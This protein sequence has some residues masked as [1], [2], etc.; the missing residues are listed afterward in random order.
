MHKKRIVSLFLSLLMIFGLMMPIQAEQP[1][2]DIIEC[3]DE[4]CYSFA[5]V[6]EVFKSDEM[7]FEE[8]VQMMI[9]ASVMQ[10]FSDEGIFEYFIRSYATTI[11]DTDIR[12][13]IEIDPLQDMCC[14]RPQIERREM[15]VCGI[16]TEGNRR[17]CI[18]NTRAVTRLCT[19]CGS[20]WPIEHTIFP[21][22][23]VVGVIVR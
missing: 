19:T 16:I 7:T 6:F 9:I 8:H 11:E 14:S 22:C 21:G 4:G 23:G 1:L 2:V 20:I 10:S 3:C 12:S 18:A 17:V 13:I 5:D 15:W